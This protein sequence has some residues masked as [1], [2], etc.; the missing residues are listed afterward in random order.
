M[1]HLLLAEPVA[2]RY[3]G[4]ACA[5]NS[6]ITAS[7][8]RGGGG[9]IRGGALHLLADPAV[10]QDLSVARG[11]SEDIEAVTPIEEAS[12]EHVAATEKEWKVSPA[13]G[14]PCHCGGAH[15]GEDNGARAM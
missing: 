14:R 7:A 8:A 6:P 13:P 12:G 10:A 11:S 9:A 4:V 15:L 3:L 1:L 2:A 5:P